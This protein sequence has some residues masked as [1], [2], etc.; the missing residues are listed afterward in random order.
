M[1][2]MASALARA[3]GPL[4]FAEASA[5]APAPHA[6]D[7]DQADSDFPRQRPWRPAAAVEE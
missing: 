3:E 5:K 1:Q 7:L 2:V 4:R 6:D